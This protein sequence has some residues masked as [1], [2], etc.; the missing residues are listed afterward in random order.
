M[1]AQT[2]FLANLTGT[3][4][5]ERVL[6]IVSSVNM[7]DT[8]SAIPIYGR[9]FAPDDERSGHVALLAYGL[10]QRRFGGDRNAIGRTLQLD[11]NTYSIIGVLSPGF[12]MLYG[13]GP[14]DIYLPLVMTPAQRQSRDSHEYLVTARLETWRN[15]CSSPIPRWTP[16]MHVC[17]REFPVYQHWSRC[18]RNGPG[19]PRYGKRE[20]G[21]AHVAGAL[22]HY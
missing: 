16:S 4:E 15:V 17:K 21:L 8:Y 10:W 11:G 14:G 7:L 18:E 1:T 2:E 13:Q 9:A 19:D 3:G 12:R 5:P 20:A 22:F 6:A